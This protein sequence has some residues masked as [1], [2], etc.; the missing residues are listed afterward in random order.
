[1]TVKILVIGSSVHRP[2]PRPL[3]IY[4]YRAYALTGQRCQDGDELILVG[5]F[6]EA[7]GDKPDGISKLCGTLELVDLMHSLH[8]SR[9]MATYARG[10]KRIDYA[11][12]TPRAAATIISGCYEPFNYRLASDH[13]AFYIDFNEAALFG[14]QFPSL[15]PLHKCDIHARNPKEV[16]KYLEA[17]YSLMQAHN[18]FARIRRLRDDSTLNPECAESIDRDLFRISI[19]AGKTC[20]KFCEPEWSTELH[21]THA[22]VGILKRVLS[23]RGTRYN[24]T[25]QIATL[26][27]QQGTSTFLIPST[28]EECKKELRKAQAEVSR[29]AQ[30][31]TQHRDTEI[32]DRI[33]ALELEGNKSKAKIL[34]NIR[35]AKEMCRL[36]AKL[37]YLRS[38]RLRCQ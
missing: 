36:F 23:M 14:S 3:S 27:H 22:R 11:L 4:L 33:A 20:Q 21:A 8:D 2:V 32:L 19:A 7:L 9:T 29:I 34:R 16:T 28:V 30:Q 25:E 15:P 6:N 13:C 12:A 24:H 26:Q 35:K 37:R 1:M 5:N 31:S 38:S 18:I 10:R 17:K